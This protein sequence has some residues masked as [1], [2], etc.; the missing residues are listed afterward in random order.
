[1]TIIS[2]TTSAGLPGLFCKRSVV[3]GQSY[4]TS[5]ERS[6]EPTRAR[7]DSQ[8][9]LNVS[10]EPPG[11]PSRVPSDQSPVGRVS[12]GSPTTAHQ[13]YVLIE[14]RQGGLRP[15]LPLASQSPWL[16]AARRRSSTRSRTPK[17]RRSRQASRTAPRSTRSPNRTMGTVATRILRSSLT[18]RAPSC[19]QPT[20][21]FR[22]APE[23]TL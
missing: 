15:P 20:P 18:G 17:L 22:P 9:E 19:R 4:R 5:G 23:P 13:D 3:S 21:L 14:A 16:H 1:M 6:P 8:P 10:S 11:V 12:L 2:I 7:R